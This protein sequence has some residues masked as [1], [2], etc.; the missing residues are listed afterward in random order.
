MKII[1]KRAI[2]AGFFIDPPYKRFMSSKVVEGSPAG[3]AASKSD[4]DKIGAHAH[5]A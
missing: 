1:K 4:L 3:I 2:A 5:R